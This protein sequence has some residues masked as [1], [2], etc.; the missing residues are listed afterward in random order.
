MSDPNYKDCGHHAITIRQSMVKEKT[1]VNTS[2]MPGSIIEYERFVNTATRILVMDDAHQGWIFCLQATRM[3][4]LA[5]KE[6]D[7]F[8]LAPTES[9][10]VVLF[11]SEAIS[12]NFPDR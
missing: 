3:N 12:R 1:Q 10:S 4:R 6:S 5:D 7:D 2:L 11:L 9:P 8:L